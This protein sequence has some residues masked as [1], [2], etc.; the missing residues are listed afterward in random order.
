MFYASPIVYSLNDLSD[1]AGG[2]DIERI[3]A[4][5]PLAGIFSLYRSAFF[6]DQLNW[7][8]VGVS[9]VMIVV[10]LIVGIWTFSRSER[11]VLKEL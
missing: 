2:L 10:L 3:A 1:I 8:A 4:F 11:L 9:A 5:N 7:Y 6:P